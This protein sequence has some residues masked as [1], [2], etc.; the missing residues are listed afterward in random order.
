MMGSIARQILHTLATKGLT[1]GGRVGLTVILGAALTPADYGAYALVMTLGS[2]GVLLLGGN[3]YAYLHR[4]VPGRPAAEQ[5]SLFKTTFIVEMIA[6]AS[7]L[8][9]LWLSG[10]VPAFLRL[11]NAE[12][13]DAPFVIGLGLLLLLVALA[14]VTSLLQ[15]RTDIEAAN[16]VDVLSQAAWVTPLAIL[17]ATG[18]RIDVSSVLLAQIGG[19]CVAL[20]IGF[21]RIGLAEW[22]R[23]A[24]QWSQVRIALAFGAAMMLPSLSFYGL[25][26]A[27]RFVLSAFWSLQ[28]VGLYSFAYSFVNM[29]YTFSAWAIFTTLGPRI[30]AAH[31]LGDV[32]QRDLL[33]T[34]MLKVAL[35]A[36]A[37]GAVV[38]M[39]VFGPLAAAIARPEY[40][41]AAG[42]IPAL[43]LAQL[44]IIAA[45]PA[46]NL[47]F[48]QNRVRASAAVDV[49][50]VVVCLGADVLLIPKWSYYG[51]AWASV[52]GFGTV[53]VGKYAL[54]GALST[55]RRD[56]LFSVA[57]ERQLAADYF[58]HL[59]RGA[60]RA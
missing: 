59:L 23:A 13:Y 31:N 43:T 53:L 4:A 20:L 50:G 12:G 51:A 56:V 29:L 57:G 18:S 38:L 46:G 7:L 33:Q 25:K 48:M 44:I 32:G 49:L 1:A 45:Y 40:A 52:L 8:T 54:S 34:Y 21:W 14:E 58:R 41:G 60:G 22:W 27:D 17:W 16:W 10:A 26:L 55:L 24:P 19:G 6:T 39:L 3:L 30:I 9:L 36:F 42:V 2:F 35:V 37:A 5:L 47:L 15:A 28:E 11:M